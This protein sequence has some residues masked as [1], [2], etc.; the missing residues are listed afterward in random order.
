MAVNLT[1]T[2]KQHAF[3]DHAPGRE[4]RWSLDSERRRVAD[5]TDFNLEQSGSTN[6]IRRF[7]NG[8]DDELNGRTAKKKADEDMMM[9]LTVGSPAYMRAYNTRLTFK[10]NGEDFE[11]TQ[12]ELH[13]QAR[14]RAEDLRKQI[15]V[16]KQRGDSVEDIA[17]MQ[18]NLAA[19]RIIRDNVDPRLGKITPDRQQAIDD[20]INGNLAVQETLRREGTVVSG[21]AASQSESVPSL[22]TTDHTVSVREGWGIADD[23]ISFVATLEAATSQRIGIFLTKEFELAKVQATP[24]EIK[25]D[26]R[27]E[28][29]SPGRGTGISI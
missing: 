5:R 20:A 23:R 4:E 2:W 8:R 28:I 19:Y 15:D 22:D 21:S 26:E 18:T 6:K 7:T 27:S 29:T 3:P 14:Q 16:A 9:L 25:S 1:N 10:I 11:I 24:H 17:R 12:G 13:D